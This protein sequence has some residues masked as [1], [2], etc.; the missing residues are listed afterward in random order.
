MYELYLLEL[1]VCIK[2]IRNIWEP[3]MLPE[4]IH[5]GNLFR[6]KE[7]L[8]GEVALHFTMKMMM[9]VRTTTTIQISIM[10]CFAIGKQW[11]KSLQNS[12]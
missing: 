5:S 2:F 7:S 9:T 6:Y 3:T 8:L 12:W 1:S 11:S 10:F 4:F